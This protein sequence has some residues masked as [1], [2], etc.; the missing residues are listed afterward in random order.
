MSSLQAQSESLVH[1]AKMFLHYAEH[2][3]LDIRRNVL[4]QLPRNTGGSAHAHAP[5]SVDKTHERT[6]PLPLEA[7]CNQGEVATTTTAD[8]GSSPYC[9]HAPPPSLYTNQGRVATTT[10]AYASCVPYPAYAPPPYVYMNQGQVA[11]TTTAVDASSPYSAYAPHDANIYISPGGDMVKTPPPTPPPPHET[12]SCNRGQ[13]QPTQPM[14]C[15]GMKLLSNAADTVEYSP[16]ATATDNT[17]QKPDFA[18][19]G[20]PATDA[21]RRGTKTAKN[22]S[23]RGTKTAKNKSSRGWK[24]WNGCNLFK[25][26]MKHCLMHGDQALDVHEYVRQYLSSAGRHCGVP[27]KHR[28]SMC[29]VGCKPSTLNLSEGEGSHLNKTGA[30]L[31]DQWKNLGDEKR[32][33]YNSAARLLKVLNTHA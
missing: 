16:R 25:S 18:D 15:P 1:L 26:H 9:A 29:T 14:G 19:D 3:G 31:L 8:D 30:F 32:A 10:T 13:A 11:T 7:C 33:M 28:I 21:P 2:M 23:R 4:E 5:F 22:K 17:T 6:P 24:G 27:R 20:T 12:A